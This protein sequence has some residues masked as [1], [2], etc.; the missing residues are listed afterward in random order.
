MQSL[1]VSISIY[2][3]LSLCVCVFLPQKLDQTVRKT[4]FIQCD[5]LN[6]SHPTQII[7]RAQ[8]SIN[9]S[10]WNQIKSWQKRFT[11][12][13]AMKYSGAN[14]TADNFHWRENN[15]CLGF[16]WRSIGSINITV[17]KLILALA[18]PL[19]KCAFVFTT[20]ITLFAHI[21]CPNLIKLMKDR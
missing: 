2:I 10:G 20:A 21:P 12:A 3:S 11:F 16:Q 8:K 19:F 13:L 9:E 17:V 14:S 4:D 15:D 6:Q 1:F 7:N 5:W 18:L